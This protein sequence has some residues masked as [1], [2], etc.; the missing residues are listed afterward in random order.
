[1]LVRGGGADA[2]GDLGRPRGE[3][4]ARVLK[5]ILKRVIAE[6]GFTIER[7]DLPPPDYLQ[8]FLQKLWPVAVN[9]PMIRCGGDAD[10]AYLL[11]DDLDGIGAL[12]S[13]GVEA[14]ATFERDMAA[15]G[16]ICYMADAS[17]TA[18]PLDNPAFRFEAKFLGLRDTDEF[19]TIDSW[20]DRYEPGDHDLLLQIDIEGAEWVVMSNMSE[21]LLRRLRIIVIE[22]HSLGQLADQYGRQTVVEVMERLLRTHHLVHNHPNNWGRLYKRGDILIPDVMEMTF[23]RKD[24]A[25]PTGY[26]TAFPHPLDIVNGPHLPPIPLPAA[27]YAPSAAG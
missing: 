8:G 21:H 25:V 5:R 20:V 18:P 14:V 13:P 22:A 3:R 11:P 6:L 23:L 12:F 9:I 17:V 19:T 7:R 4:M 24:R 2:V 1:M 16:M 27:W 26:V 10:G 15:R